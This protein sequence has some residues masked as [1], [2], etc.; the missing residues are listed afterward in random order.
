MKKL[1]IVLILMALV[2]PVFAQN[3]SSADT[4]MYYINIPV[5]K[6][7]LSH[8]GYVIQYRKGVNQIATI[9]VPYAWF[10]D[11]A[12]RAEIMYLQPGKDWPSLSVFYKEG[13]F[14]HVRLY[15]HRWKKHPTWSV[16]PQGAD[17]SRHFKEPDSFSLEF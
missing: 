4:K 12:S 16:V 14:S 10:T 3:N 8:E 1:I 7:Y 6:V 2:L 5:E 13:E 9:G 15:L 11:S 17:V